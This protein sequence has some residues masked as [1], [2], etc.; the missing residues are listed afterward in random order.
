MI[1]INQLFECKK[2]RKC[3]AKTEYGTIQNWFLFIWFFINFGI[4]WKLLQLVKKSFYLQ[5]ILI[6]IGL[7][8]GIFTFFLVSKHKFYF[9]FRIL[10]FLLFFLRIT[11]IY[12]V[13]LPALTF[14]EIMPLFMFWLY[15]RKAH[16]H[17]PLQTE[18]SAKTQR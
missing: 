6:C 2:Q 5:M 1:R 14:V 9:T 4:R 16:Q 15:T 10:F 12:K 17:C 18:T 3:C 7:S 8:K 11:N 13:Q